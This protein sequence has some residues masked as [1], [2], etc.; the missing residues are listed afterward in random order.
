MPAS[1]LPRIVITGGS[2]FIG[3]RLAQLATELGYQVTVTTAVNNGTERTRCD[4]LAKA[5][6]TVIVAPLED[7]ATLERA[8]AGQDVVIH[9]AAAQHEA[10]APESHFH[11]VNVEGTQRLLELASRTGVRRF[12]HGSTIG[13]YGQATDGTLDEHSPLAPDN[14]YGRTKAAAEQ[15]V[16]QCAGNLEY[17]IIRIS[18]TYGPGDMRLLKLFKG[19]R[20]GRFL[21]VGSGTNLHQ[22]IYADDLARGLLAA[23]A[24]GRANG[25]TIVLAGSE[26]IS[27]TELVTAVGAAVGRA[28][29]L[30]QVP[31]WPFVAAAYVLESSLRPIGIKP[32]LHRRRLDFFRKSFRFSTEKA[33]RLLDFR[34]QV[35]FAEGA[36]Q[37]AAWYSA[38]GYL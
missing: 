22:L 12:V 20:K 38:N 37:S 33:Q 6:I 26:P 32:P 29:R 2:G 15:V 34:A 28:K 11:R 5:G 24:A 25:E 9:L 8:L 27:T 10:Q 14:P 18:E 19:I 21:V 16:R 23:C 13:V 7:A 31:M 35:S 30:P 4:A 1:D 3:S 36:R 17:C